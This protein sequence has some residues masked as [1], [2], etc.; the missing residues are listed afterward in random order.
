MINLI[1][2]VRIQSATILRGLMTAYVLTGMMLMEEKIAQ[3]VILR[4]KKLSCPR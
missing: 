1:H 2:A 4:V 3:V